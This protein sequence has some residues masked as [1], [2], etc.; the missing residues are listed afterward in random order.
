MSSINYFILGIS[1]I[2]Y[3]AGFILALLALLHTRTPQGTFA[4]MISLIV[5][6]YVSVP[7]YLIFGPKRFEGYIE[8][9]RHRTDDSGKLNYLSHKAL[10]LKSIRTPRPDGQ[11]GRL[12]ESLRK[13]VNLD[14]TRGNDCELLIDG[15]QAFPAMYA[16]IEGAT[17]YILVEFFIIKSDSVGD[18]LRDLL[19]KK[20]KEGVRVYV[21]YDEIGSRKLRMGY[22]SALREAGVHI[23]PFN[24]KRSFFRN[25]VRVNFRN[26]RKIVVAD[27]RVC[28]IGGMNV[29]KEYIGEGKMGYWR[30]TVVKMEGPSVLQAQLTFMEDWHW[31][32]NGEILSLG[33]TPELKKADR[34]VMILPSSPADPSPTW[35]AA[36]IALANSSER[37]LWIASPYFVPDE[38]VLSA[39]QAAALRGVDVCIIKPKK[40]DKIMVKLSSLTFIP[41]TLPYGIRMMEYNN[42]FMH[43]KVILAD[44]DIAAIGT[45]NL[46]NRS[47]TLNFEITAII[48]DRDIAGQTAQM[49]HRDMEDSSLL[50]EADYGGKSLLFR[51]L[52]GICRLMAPV[53]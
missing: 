7:L 49:L 18:N 1:I 21:I 4:W 17:Q 24:G 32:T 33:W 22:I 52:C 47:L 46:D 2:F 40:A 16:A 29:G 45:A 27:G 44:D 9:R 8:A 25:I 41:D 11:R 19:I 12:F 30:D 10:S 34:Q 48:H 36:V 5:F 3:A 43:Q 51:V 35:Q 20:A 39:L 50:T 23:S 28:F 53:Q 37:R 38:A 13:L 31:S 15:K 6:P 42:G 14:I 26:H